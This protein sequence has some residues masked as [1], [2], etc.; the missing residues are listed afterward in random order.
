MGT[1]EIEDESVATEVPT[2][3]ITMEGGGIEPGNPN[4][5]I[6]EATMEFR[7]FEDVREQALQNYYQTHYG[8]VSSTVHW[9]RRVVRMPTS[10]LATVGFFGSLTEFEITAVAH[11]V[12]EF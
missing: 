5:V 12:R 8:Y 4:P 9:M 11:M 10:D 6:V 7:F 3:E 2:E 1:N